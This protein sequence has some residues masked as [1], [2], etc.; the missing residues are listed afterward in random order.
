MKVFTTKC[1][2]FRNIKYTDSAIIIDAYTLDKG[3]R[4][5]IVKGIKAKSSD[6]KPPYFQLFSMLDIVAYDG[7]ED[8]LCYL[9][10][11][12]PYHH[13]KNI[14]SN[15]FKSSIGLFMIE[16]CRNTIKEKEANSDLYYFLSE[17]FVLLDETNQ[18][19]A[20]FHLKFLIELSKYLGFY[21]H[22]E[23]FTSEQPCIF[24]LKE[25]VFQDT[26]S[27]NEYTIE[28]SLSQSIH[29]LIVCT[30]DALHSINFNYAV[31]QQVLDVLLKYYQYHIE[32]FKPSKSLEIWRT[33]LS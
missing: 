4:S 23:T 10:S 17:Q 29:K 6:K 20:D 22:S 31:R 26:H 13:Y 9:K 30:N 24:N 32:G 8:K 7:H 1:I 16:I 3:L 2:I 33:V 28:P 14:H 27:F 11:A 18:S 15:I 19:Y 5:Y 12:H 21:P 25:G